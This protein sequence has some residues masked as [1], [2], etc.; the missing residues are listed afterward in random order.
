MTSRLRIVLPMVLGVLT[1]ILTVWDVHNWRVI[2]SMGMAWDIG[3]PIWPYQTSDILLR[4]VNLPAYFVGMPLANLLKL[5]A[6][7][8]HLTVFPA[9]LAWWWFLG[10]TLDDGRVTSPSRVG[11][12]AF[13]KLSILVA[14]MLWLAV[15][16]SVT[17]FHWWMTY[18]DGVSFSL[19]ILLR[20]LTPAVWCCALVA[21]LAWKRTVAR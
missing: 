3:A 17:A 9:V 14:V 2:E 1:L 20:I 12:W 7:H 5:P 15:S 11:W 8:H 21:L 19:L 6:P 4:L 16:V 10:K 18:S 13:S